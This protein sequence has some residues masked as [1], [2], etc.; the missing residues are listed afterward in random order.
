MIRILT[1]CFIVFLFTACNLKEKEREKVKNKL[2][3]DMESYFK[4]EAE[5]MSKKN[6]PINKTVSIN[7]KTERKTISIKNWEREWHAF[8]DAD[9]NKASWRGAFKLSDVAGTKT[10][11]TENEKIPVKKL[12]ITAKNGKVTS[13]KIFI[14]NVNDL[15]VSK[16]SLSYFPDSLYH[17]VKSQKIKL[18]GQKR[19]EIVGLLLQ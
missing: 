13:I 12:E 19:Y 3:F 5:R 15:Y 6:S 7:G 4:K 11:T 14:D 8:L 2:Y 1:I 10:Y 16:D 18:M 9:I 17:I